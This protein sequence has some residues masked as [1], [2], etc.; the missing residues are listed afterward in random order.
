MAKVIIAEKIDDLGIEMLKKE[1]DVD[2]CIGIS[3]ED[4]LEKIHEYDALIVRSAT[5]VNEELLEKGVKLKIVGRAGNGTDNIDIPAATKKG[6]IIANTP[7]SNSISA[8]ELTIGLMLAQARDIASADLSLKECKWERNSFEGTE[9]FNKTLGI[10]GLGRIGSL[11]ARRMKAFG[12][13]IIGYDPYISQDR[14]DRF[15]VQKKNTLEDLLKE[16]DFITIH[17]PRTE[18]TIGMI[19]YKEFEIM[20]PN[21]RLTNVARGRIVDE[22]ALYYA[23]KNNKIASAGLDVHEKEPRGNSPLNELCNIIVTPHIGANT[24]DAQQNVGESIASQVISGLNGQIVLNAVNLPGVHLDEFEAI[25]PYLRMMERLGKLYYQLNKESVKYVEVTYW[26]DIAKA[27]TGLVSIAFLKGL[28]EP[29]MGAS[30][31]YINANISAEAAGI[32]ISYKKIKESHKNFS[33]L[34][35]IKIINNKMEEFTMSGAV[36]TNAEGKLVNLNGYEVDVKLSR[37]ML[38]IQNNDVPGVIG[39]VG[40]LI[41]T[42]GINV[43]TMQ[44]GR[45]VKGDK[46]LMLLNIDDVITKENIA[47]F[48]E[49]N[50]IIWAKSVTL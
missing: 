4:L 48:N 33:N 31:N 41:G 9:L 16:S 3:R 2:V 36:S 29:I 43:A 21:A 7:D 19:S 23:L 20:K 50:D 25:K 39:S 5:K 32:G 46:A 47:K 18:E 38:F 34:V 30:I 14:F 28:L 44:V 6:V 11:V 24:V 1:F 35:E 15:D 22:E 17:T 10:I 8:C 45:V 12:M 27:D 13:N 26:G 42:C 40:T 37:Y 49:V